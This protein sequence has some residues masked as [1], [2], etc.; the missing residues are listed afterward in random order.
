MTNNRYLVWLEW[1]EACFR[2]HPEDIRYLKTLVP[3]G[4]SVSCVHSEAA[5]LRALPRATH[6]IV[7][8]FKHE[9]FVRAKNLKVLAT[10]GAGRELV[11]HTDVPAGVTVHFGGYH[12][13]VISETVV[14]FVFAWAHGFFRPELK[15]ADAAGPWR[16]NWPRALLGDRC[17]LVAGTKAVIAGYGRIGKTIGAKL[18][19]LGVE[20][21]GFGRSNLS[22][23]PAAAK[24]ADWFILALPSD[25]GTDGF[26]G[27]SLLA[28]LPRRCVVVNV[29]RGNAIDEPALLAA[30]RSG[31]LAGAY[32]DVFSREPGPLAKLGAAASESDILGTNSADLPWNLIRT[33][34]SSAFCNQY[35]KLCFKELKDE[36]LI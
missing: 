13:A 24:T 35:V 15:A 4:S 21:R 27:P 31:R 8:N 11:A 23:L 30:L 1:P 26:L 16:T 5:F 20:V 12:G 3:R 6:A 18:A 28:K 9:W 33:P 22:D 29:G 34:H 19:A 32:L 14:G 7:W 10:P 25:T 36:G 17:S 2:A